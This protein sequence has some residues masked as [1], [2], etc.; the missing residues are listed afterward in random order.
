MIFD[1]VIDK[2]EV[3]IGR[4]V[5]LTSLHQ[6]HQIHQIR[7]YWI[8]NFKSSKRLELEYALQQSNFP[9]LP[10]QENYS[11]LIRHEALGEPG[12]EPLRC[13]RNTQLEQ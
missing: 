9:T 2:S 11:L 4:A 3:A 5:S 10:Q 1:W 7:Y 8:I 12:T 13:C 6:N